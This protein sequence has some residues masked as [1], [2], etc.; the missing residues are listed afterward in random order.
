MNLRP[1]PAPNEAWFNS[2]TGAF[3]HTPE[4]PVDS[5]RD[6]PDRFD[7]ADRARLGAFRHSGWTKLRNRVFAAFVR[8]DRIHHNCCQES[9]TGSSIQ[10][11]KPVVT[12][13]RRTAF[14]EC[15]QDAWVQES[16]TQPGV[17]RV[18]SSKCKDRFCVPCSNDRSRTAQTIL[19]EKLTTGVHRFIT[20]TLRSE[21]E[22]L[23]SQVDRLYSSF[24]KLRQR[25]FWKSRVKGGVA[26]VEVKWSDKGNRWHPHLHIVTHGRFLPVKDLGREWYAVTGDSWIV[27]VRA[28]KDERKAASYCAKYATKGY[29][30]SA[31]ATNARLIEC[32]KVFR[33]RRFVIAFGDWKGLSLTEEQSETG[34]RIIDTLANVLAKVTQGDTNACR[35]LSLLKPE[36]DEE[37]AT[38]LRGP[39]SDSPKTQPKPE[40]GSTERQPTLF[41]LATPTRPAWSI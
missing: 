13:T 23:Q 31:I 30:A 39:P 36:I 1:L 12:R 40:Q 32:I 41:T 2:R 25:V 33:G 27:D 8:L 3:V 5:L 7:F 35:I 19:Q 4:T 29:D 26:F 37:L 17:F 34:W 15:G 22:S 14:A 6:A 18:V 9:L 24:R 28:I 21:S 10:P 20:L 11:G 16:T 38:H